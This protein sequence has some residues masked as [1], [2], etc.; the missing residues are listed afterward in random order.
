MLSFL[1]LVENGT[2]QTAAIGDASI[3]ERGSEQMVIAISFTRS[4]TGDA[5]AA[6]PGESKPN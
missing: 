6:V 1:S 2:S 3:V 4:K 5:A